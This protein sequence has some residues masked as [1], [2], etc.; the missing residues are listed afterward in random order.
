MMQRSY[1]PERRQQRSVDFAK[2]GRLL[3][4]P[5]PPEEESPMVSRFLVKDDGSDQEELPA[6]TGPNQPYSSFLNST[7]TLPV[8]VANLQGRSSSSSFLNRTSS[9]SYFPQPARRSCARLSTQPS[10]GA[11]SATA[12]MRERHRGPS[13]P[14]LNFHAN[15][16][17]L[18]DVRRKE[19]QAKDE[20]EK[21]CKLACD[22]K[23][24][25]EARDLHEFRERIKRQSQKLTLQEL[26]RL[27]PTYRKEYIGQVYRESDEAL[28]QITEVDEKVKDK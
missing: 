21:C 19:K 8:P 20:A 26:R 17:D 23:M 10:L 22:Q 1:D 9:Q 11:R 25:R 12:Y 18:I 3:T 6:T 28:E 4:A 13:R 14:S 7:S 15:F 27:E 16:V 2:N 24:K 5:A